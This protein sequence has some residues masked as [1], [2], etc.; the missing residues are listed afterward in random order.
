MTDH[1]LTLGKTSPHHF[2]H[3]AILC[4]LLFACTAL[5]SAVTTLIIGNLKAVVTTV[6]ILHKYYVRRP[7]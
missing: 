6:R 7:P 5:N 3:A 2:T 1:L 4:F